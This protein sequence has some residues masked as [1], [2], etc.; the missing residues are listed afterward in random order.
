MPGICPDCGN[1]H[2]GSCA[3]EETYFVWEPPS[4]HIP[5]EVLIC[6]SWKKWQT[7]DKLTR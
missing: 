7:F 3:T 1:V 2:F 6:G 5:K 4:H